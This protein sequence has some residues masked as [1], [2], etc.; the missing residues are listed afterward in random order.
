[1]NDSTPHTTKVHIV[2][3]T[4]SH[5][6]QRI[7]NFLMT[8][9][10]GVPKSRVYRLLRKGEVRVNKKRIDP[11]YKLAYGDE[12]R[13]PPV[14]QTEPSELKPGTGL[15][16]LMTDNILYED[17]DLLIIN[18]PAGMAVHAGSNIKFGIIEVLRHIRPYQPFL[19]LAHRLDRETSGCLILAK[20]RDMLLHLHDAF[21]HDGIKKCYQVLVHGVWPAKLTKVNFALVKGQVQAGERMVKVADEV[22][23][24]S[25]TEFKVLRRFTNQTL[26]QAR[27]YT[28]RTHQIR[29]HAAESGYPI[30]G[31]EK[32]GNRELD[33]SL[34]SL[35]AKGMYLHSALVEL[36]IPGK[37]Q[38]LHIDAPLPPHWQML[39]DKLGVQH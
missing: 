28:G 14:R 23:K 38:P 24:A 31:D 4:Q 30:I 13:I 29:V 37:S 25:L 6:G 10:K 17:E 15:I 20:N 27:L 26:L 8:Y 7:D 21:K 11:E 19:E 32:Y 33:K 36:P 9:L 22:G 2:S 18:K 35:G 34:R 1:M 5:A 12:V 16:A 3:I 39:M